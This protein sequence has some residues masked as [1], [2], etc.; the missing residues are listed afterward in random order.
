ML[1]LVALEELLEPQRQLEQQV[2]Q[3][4]LLKLQ[5]QQQVIR[6]EVIL[7]LFLALRLLQLQQLLV[8]SGHFNPASQVRHQN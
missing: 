2:L 4:L 5:P 8:M 6:V 3:E 7:L 1:L